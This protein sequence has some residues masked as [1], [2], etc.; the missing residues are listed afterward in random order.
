MISDKHKCIFIHIIK[1]GG[2]SIERFFHGEISEASKMHRIAKVYK[3]EIGS[4]KW[5]KYFTFTFVRNP[6]CKMV[7]QYFYIQRRKKGKYKLT[8][9]EFI[10]AFK[11]CSE[12]EYINHKGIAVKFNPIQLPWILDDDG[13]CI[14][15]FVGRFENLQE[16]FNLICDKI[17]IPRKKLPHLNKSEHEHYTKY[18]DDETKQI[19]AEKFAKDIEYFGYKFGD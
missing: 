19:V 15:D 18:Y 3:E 8:F 16:D 2:V 13:N 9:R 14:V 17:G 7:S 4:E 1:T 11:S 12:S 6:W 5:N 10:L